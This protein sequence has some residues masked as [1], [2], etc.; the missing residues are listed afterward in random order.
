MNGRLTVVF[1][2]VV[3]A[4]AGARAAGRTLYVD[5]RGGSDENA[6]TSPDR[7][8]KTIS[9]G[10]RILRGG[11]K[12]IVGPGVYY[13]RPVFG[14]MGTSP[15]KPVWILA[16]PRGQAVISGAWQAA[17]EGKVKWTPE[18]DGVCATRRTPPSVPSTPACLAWGSR[19]TVTSTTAHDPHPERPTVSAAAA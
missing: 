6:G 1:V 18:G 16:Q 10:A 4:C 2:I 19:F 9:A 3:L 17:A 7:A 8:L 12:L 15:D 13:E 5:G 11:D 14:D